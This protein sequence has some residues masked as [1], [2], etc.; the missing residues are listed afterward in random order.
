M[1]VSTILTLTLFESPPGTLRDQ[2]LY[3]TVVNSDDEFDLSANS[4]EWSDQDLLTVLLLVDLPDLASRS[5][6]GDP[7][8]GLS[9]KLE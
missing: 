8:K 5:G 7:M 4:S 1:I 2:L 6:D 9:T 3:P